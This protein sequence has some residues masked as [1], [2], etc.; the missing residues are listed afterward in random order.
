MADDTVM[1]VPAGSGGAR[2]R[3]MRFERR[4]MRQP[5]S[6]IVIRAADGSVEDRVDVLDSVNEPLLMSD[7]AGGAEH[8]IT[9]HDFEQ[10]GPP[11]ED[12]DRKVVFATSVSLA[13]NLLLL[14]AKAW[15]FFAS[16]SMAVAASMADSG[17]DLASQVVLFLCAR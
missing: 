12:G 10:M 7:G 14:V 9:T 15:A 17:V 2:R 4:I 8:R 1:D 3:S 16:G 5:S 11:S 6:V 13:A